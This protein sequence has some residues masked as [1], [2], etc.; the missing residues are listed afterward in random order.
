MKVFSPSTPH[1]FCRNKTWLYDQVLKR[2][3][4][5]SVKVRE[6]IKKV[7][8]EMPEAFFRFYVLLAANMAI[9]GNY[10][11]PTIQAVLFL[12]LRQMGQIVKFSLK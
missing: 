4:E 2:T 9:T 6:I 12:A 5:L 8:N 10:F 3:K 1:I 7:G 11:G